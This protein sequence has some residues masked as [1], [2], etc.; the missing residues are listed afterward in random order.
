[1]DIDGYRGGK[2]RFSLGIMTIIY[3]TVTH[4]KYGFRIHTGSL[5]GSTCHV[6]THTL[7]TR[8]FIK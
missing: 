3:T 2:E 4:S 6:S 1:M 7:K 8:I 5:P